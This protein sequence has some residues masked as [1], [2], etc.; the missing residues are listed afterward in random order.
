MNQDK[1]K[2]W[3][4]ISLQEHIYWYRLGWRITIEDGW[5]VAYRRE[6]RR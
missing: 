2:R 3:N 4:E 5:I 6:M 1:P